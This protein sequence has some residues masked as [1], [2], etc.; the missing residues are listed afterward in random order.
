M[1]KELTILTTFSIAIILVVTGCQHSSA[2]KND[3]LSPNRSPAIL[4][5]KIRQ[6]KKQQQVKPQSKKSQLRSLLKKRQLQQVY[7]QR[8]VPA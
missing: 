8:N 2:S 4:H 6:S 3:S 1:K 7:F 5:P